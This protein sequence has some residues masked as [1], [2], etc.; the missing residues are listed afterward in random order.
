MSS[1]RPR[2][3]SKPTTGPM[4]GFPV[5]FPEV[6]APDGGLAEPD[7]DHEG[8]P[9]GEADGLAASSGGTQAPKYA[10]SFGGTGATPARAV[11]VILGAAPAPPPQPAAT[12]ATTAAVARSAVPTIGNLAR[13]VRERAFTSTS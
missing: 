5:S 6:A 10:P 2:S 4:P 7:G 11:V 13:A 1:C 9:E 3:C 12:V 8:D